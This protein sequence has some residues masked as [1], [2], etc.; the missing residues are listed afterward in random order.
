[1]K[2]KAL[3]LSILSISL[4]GALAAPVFG[5]IVPRMKLQ[6]LVDKSDRIL[7]GRVD[8]VEVRVTGN[9]PF[10]W[11]RVRVDDPICERTVASRRCRQGAGE[12][13]QAVFLRY[14]GGVVNTPNGPVEMRVSGM[15]TF[16]PG[17]NV[18]LFLQ[19]NPDGTN[20]V[21][22]LNQGKYVVVGEVAVANVS[23]VELMDPKTGKTSPSGF[24]ESAPVGAF[25][26]KIR[27]LVK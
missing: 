26:S 19:E 6:D 24:T 15:P 8:A 14:L 4:M 20:Q 21:V 17:D 18:I 16:Q 23:G 12:R 27:E 25:L 10:T 1:M 7:Q 13:R 22:G 9:R 2:T 11:V 3:L 5:T